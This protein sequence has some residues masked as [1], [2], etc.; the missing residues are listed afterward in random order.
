MNN[1]FESSDLPLTQLAPTYAQGSIWLEEGMDKQVATFDLVIRDLPKNRNYLVSGGLEEF[2]HYLTSLKYSADQIQLLLKG[3]LITKKFAQYLKEFRFSG[4]V[5]AMPEGTIF[6]PGEPIVRIT[7][8]IIE[9]SLI[10]IALFGITVSNVL[11]MSKAARL[12]SV[13]ENI[14]L[15]M[16]RGQAFEA[17]LKGLR[18]GHICGL[19]TC[20][21][22]VF[23]EKYNLPR[24]RDYLVNGQ[25]FFIKSFPNEITA[26][27]KLAQYFPDN[28]SFMIDTYDIEQGLE[29]AVTV[30]QELKKKGSQ[31]R[32][33][34]VDAGDLEKLSRTV[35]RGLDQNGLNKVQIIAA[36]NLDEYKVKKLLDRKAPIDQF[37][38]ATEYVTVSDAP[39]L[40]V[41]Y[42]IAE[43]RD[44]KNIR[45]TAKLT[46]GK[47]SY[48]GRKQVFRQFKKGKM[49]CDTVGL[50]GEK[51]GTPL[52]K[53][54]I[55]QGKPVGKS[56]T[57]ESTQKYFNKQLASL[58]PRL[59]DI[60]KQRPYPVKVSKKL[61][62]L[63]S[64]VKREHIK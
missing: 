27:R 48:P 52:L 5:Q 12:R 22:P 44:G 64:Q 16:Q 21:W 38:V 55:R 7:A 49:F 3:G 4:D 2:V 60:N 41:V 62:S 39:S 14:N 51:H 13:S 43:L 50:E 9:A 11:Y 34:T 57:L 8:P 58:P 45:Y 19:I 32:Y 31:L 28:T 56:P 36:T 6:F 25:H 20:A 54:V 33:V 46:P 15:G 30:G 24:D 10:E 26:F 1:L 59:L 63:L 42:K 40:E 53:K 35:R 29:N 17:G 18:S 47:I 61:T 23:V 37:I